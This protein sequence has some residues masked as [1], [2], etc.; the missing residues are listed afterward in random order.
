MVIV[1][2]NYLIMTIIIKSFT[3]YNM[4]QAYYFTIVILSHWIICAYGVV[5]VHCRGSLTAV[6]LARKQCFLTKTYF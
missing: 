4:A 5:G 2:F 6:D 3:L 1:F